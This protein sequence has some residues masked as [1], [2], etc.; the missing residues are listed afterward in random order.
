M[1]RLP[2][3]FMTVGGVWGIHIGVKHGATCILKGKGKNLIIIPF[4]NVKD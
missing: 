2:N 3:T 1:G 4:A